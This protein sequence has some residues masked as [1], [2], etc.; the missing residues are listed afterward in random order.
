LVPQT[1]FIGS[2]GLRGLTKC[3]RFYSHLHDCNGY[4]IS[5]M[6]RAN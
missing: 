5:K 1:P 6:E 3:Q 4:F 2:P